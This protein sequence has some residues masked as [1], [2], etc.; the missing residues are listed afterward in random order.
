MGSE[1][2]SIAHLTRVPRRYRWAAKIDQ[3]PIVGWVF[4]SVGVIWIPVVVGIVISVLR[5]R[6]SAVPLVCWVG[7]ALVLVQVT[8]GLVA[9]GAKKFSELEAGAAEVRSLREFLDWMHAQ[10]FSKNT[11]TRITLMVPVKHKLRSELR[12]FLRPSVFPSFS[13]TRL[14]VDANSGTG[15]GVAGV[16][17]CENLVQRLS[18]K[19]DQT[20]DG[21]G[22]AKETHLPSAKSGGITRRAKYYFAVPIEIADAEHLLG[23]LIIDN[24]KQDRILE[25]ASR[26]DCNRIEGSIQLVAPWI[27]RMLNKVPPK[28]INRASEQQVNLLMR[29]CRWTGRP[30]KYVLVKLG[31]C[32]A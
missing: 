26:T 19:V 5:G 2:N 9:L 31:V 10:L 27:A 8:S 6:E 16:C 29:A 24:L 12:V 22:Y 28:L 32:A 17:F 7:S 13:D 21:E 30:I 11:S 14:S 25:N 15:E 20:Q 18:P 3:M 1:V 23:V 4:G